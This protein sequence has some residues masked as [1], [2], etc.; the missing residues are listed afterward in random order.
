MI[1]KTGAAS[2]TY[3]ADAATGAAAA[4]KNSEVTKDAFLQLLVA[5]VKNQDPLNPTD[6]VQFLSQLAQFTQ[7]EQTIGMRTDLQDIAA[8]LKPTE[9]TTSNPGET[10]V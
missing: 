4:K 6:G 7:L 9:T 8:A 1:D 3:G 5:Q 2:S 10:N